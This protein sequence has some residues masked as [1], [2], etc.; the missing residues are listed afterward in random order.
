MT[1][2]KSSPVVMAFAFSIGDRVVHRTRNMTGT[3]IDIFESPECD[4]VYE[5]KFCDGVA[6]FVCE[7]WLLFASD[8]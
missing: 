8:V 6:R 3:V 4:V 2:D 5:V 1:L 7:S